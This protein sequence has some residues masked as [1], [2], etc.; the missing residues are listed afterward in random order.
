MNI[1]ILHGI[2]IGTL[3]ILYLYFVAKMQKWYFRK[4][5]NYKLNNSVL[6]IYISSLI[7]SL[8]NLYYFSDLATQAFLFFANSSFFMKAFE[9]S[10]IYFVI[11]FILSILLF[12]F[13]F[14]FVGSLTAENE[15]AELAKDNRELAIM[16]AFV[17][18]GLSII[19][20]PS[21]VIIASDFI[22]YS[23]FAN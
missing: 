3:S 21:L 2:L 16:H 10:A 23:E 13:S 17:V 15:M 8:I 6:T 20:G 19:L 9:Y 18:I 22:P 12:R 1:G 7:M 11:A 4:L 5:F 14:L